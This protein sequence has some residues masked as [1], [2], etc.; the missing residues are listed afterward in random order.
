MARTTT[1]LSALLLNLLG[2][3]VFS[4]CFAPRAPCCDK[5]A[6]IVTTLLFKVAVAVVL[7]NLRVYPRGLRRLP[8]VCFFLYEL[9]CCLLLIEFAEKVLWAAL[10]NLVYEKISNITGKVNSSSSL[11]HR[12]KQ[13]DVWTQRTR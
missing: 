9:I 5:T 10:E 8:G 13:S 2:V 11:D 1:V 7:T 4:G 3:D 12:N 6:P